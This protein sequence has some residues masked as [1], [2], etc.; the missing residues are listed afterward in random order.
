MSDDVSL[1]DKFIL[2]FLI[3]LSVMIP[4]QIFFL[5][6]GVFSG[7]R[8][9]L[10]ITPISS[11][12]FT[13]ALLFVFFSSNPSKFVR[14]F[15]HRLVSEYDERWQKIRETEN[16]SVREYRRIPIVSSELVSLSGI[17]NRLFV[18]SIFCVFFLIGQLAL[19]LEYN[20][21]S[22]WLLPISG[23]IYMISAVLFLIIIKIILVKPNSKYIYDDGNELIFYT[24]G[25][26]RTIPTE[27]IESMDV[28]RFNVVLDTGD[29]KIKLWVLNPDRIRDSIMASKI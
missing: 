18:S 1:F 2:L 21:I 24:H 25:G 15:K 29:R 12:F 28:G 26:V 11:S 13:M 4:I 17:L 10:F 14:D 22:L 5:V 8:L 9:E 20:I 19:N 23:L 7:I 27:Y 6:G 16:K 3:V